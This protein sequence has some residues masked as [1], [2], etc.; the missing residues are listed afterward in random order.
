[1]TTQCRRDAT[2]QRSPPQAC[3]TLKC[4]RVCRHVG[5]RAQLVLVTVGSA[6]PSTGP[7]VQGQEGKAGQGAGHRAQA[8]TP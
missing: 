1:M 6:A 5:L 2:S 3:H 4:P 8:V 7:G